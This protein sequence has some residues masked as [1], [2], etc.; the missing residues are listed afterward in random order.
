[1]RSGPFQAGEVVLLV[2]RKGRRYLLRLQPGRVHD[3]R[4]LSL[5]HI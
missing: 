1:M 2:D 5:I 4:G 3:L